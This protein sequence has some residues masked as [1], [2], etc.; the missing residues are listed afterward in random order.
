MGWREQLFTEGKAGSRVCF[1]APNPLP[2]NPALAQEHLENRRL[3][4]ISPNKA[5]NEHAGSKPMWAQMVITA[6]LD[7]GSPPG[8]KPWGLHT[9]TGPTTCP[10]APHSRRC[11]SLQLL[12]LSP[13]SSSPI[14][15]LDKPQSSPGFLP[16]HTSPLMP[17]RGQLAPKMISLGL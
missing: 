16:L 2:W 14:P 6:A 9:H 17:N 3:W 15:T 11:C 13:S 8:R 4:R 1:A 7:G 5:G 12:S 10:R